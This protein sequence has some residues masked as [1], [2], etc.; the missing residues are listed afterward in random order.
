MSGALSDCFWMQANEVRRLR[1]AEIL[2]RELTS[3]ERNAL[4]KLRRAGPSNHVEISKLEQS[5]LTSLRLVDS[6]GGSP[7]LTDFG[8][9]VVAE[10][11]SGSRFDT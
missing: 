4:L 6:T 8:R 11:V 3:D 10:L 9:E 1:P 2:A 7:R 5:S